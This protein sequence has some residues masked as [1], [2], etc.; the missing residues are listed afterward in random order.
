MHTLQPARLRPGV[1]LDAESGAETATATADR[2]GG[3]A[4][5]P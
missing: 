3:R 4:G 2:A 1:A 5:M